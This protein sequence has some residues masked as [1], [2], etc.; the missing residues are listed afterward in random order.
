M[1]SSL[2]RSGSTT[3]WR[4]I[5]EA[6][7]Q[8]DG[9]MCVICGEDEGLTVDHIHERQHGGGDDP[10][11]LQTLCR[12]CHKAKSAQSHSGHKG[13]KGQIRL[14]RT[15]GGFFEGGR[16]PPTP[17]VLLSPRIGQNGH[18]RTGSSSDQTQSVSHG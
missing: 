12:R 1:S 2:K 13:Q 14:N 7:I 17:P 8:R 4:K 11:N 6:V 3:R 10:H 5:R 9:G 16:T 18:H 15:S